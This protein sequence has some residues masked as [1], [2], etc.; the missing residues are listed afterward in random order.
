MDETVKLDISVEIDQHDPSYDTG[1]TV[2]AW[3][4]LNDDQR[5]ALYQEAW[6]SLAQRDN[7]GVRVIT[8]GAKAL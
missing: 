3:N 5:S 1:L 8:P 2:E 6:D 7:G 4:A